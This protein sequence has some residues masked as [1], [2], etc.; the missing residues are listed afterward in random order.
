MGTIS[1][2]LVARCKEC[3][4]RFTWSMDNFPFVDAEIVGTCDK[5]FKKE[6]HDCYDELE[7]NENG[8]FLFVG[9]KKFKGG[10]E[11]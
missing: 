9:R 6:S 7:E 2:S 11:K 4:C 1:G 8:G 5:C 3:N 10:E